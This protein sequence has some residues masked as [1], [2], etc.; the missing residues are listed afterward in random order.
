MINNENINIIQDMSLNK[1]IIYIDDPF[2]LD[3]LQDLLPYRRVYGLNHRDSLLDKIVRV[4]D[5]RDFGA[6]DEI[7]VNK[8]LSE[9]LKQ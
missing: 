5:T 8:N 1:E 2:V 7:L 4:K 3:D 6:L 9:F